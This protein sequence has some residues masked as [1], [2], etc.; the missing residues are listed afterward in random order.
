MVFLVQN[1]DKNELYMEIEL[2]RQFKAKCS[3]FRRFKT[4]NRPI[5]LV[6][7]K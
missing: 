2:F 4:P 1:D 6:S 3:I 5:L 7:Q